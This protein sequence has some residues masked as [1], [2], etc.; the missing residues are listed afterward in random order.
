VNNCPLCGGNGVAMFSQFECDTSGC[1]NYKKR[2]TPLHVNERA[3][4]MG[5]PNYEWVTNSQKG[6]A[7]FAKFIVG[8][9]KPSPQHSRAA[10][11]RMGMVG[12]YRHPTKKG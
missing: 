11:E 12:L 7:H 4:D 6:A 2:E 1:S 3:D 10:L 5:A 8:P 9:P